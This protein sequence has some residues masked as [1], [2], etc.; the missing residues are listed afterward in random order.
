M[1][2]ARCLYFSR[3]VHVADDLARQKLIN[4]VARQSQ[5]NNPSVGLTGVLTMSNDAFLQ[6]LEG[7]RAEISALIARLFADDRHSELV[8][9]EIVP[10]G[11]RLFGNWAM[12]PMLAAEDGAL[13]FD[14]GALTRMGPGAMLKRIADI[15]ANA[16]GSVLEDPVEDGDV[17]W[18]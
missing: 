11:E 12:A 6:V 14:Y 7:P 9:A 4:G 16:P 17:L 18:I 15:A 1:Q 10:T 8:V 2:L 13:A 5:A 3:S